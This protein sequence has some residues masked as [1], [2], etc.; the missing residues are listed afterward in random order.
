MAPKFAED[1]GVLTVT[2][3][4]LNARGVPLIRER[5][6]RLGAYPRSALVFDLR[7]A[8]ATCV[9][10]VPALVALFRAHEGA[11]RERLRAVAFVVRH[12]W[13]REALLAAIELAP[14]IA[15]HAIVDA[16]D[17]ARLFCAEALRT[18]LL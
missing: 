6:E 14:A 2:I 15:D 18:P 11:L 7:D 4:G 10:F 16:P 12:A 8:R 17:D 5:V 13:V 9:P 1:G 3:R